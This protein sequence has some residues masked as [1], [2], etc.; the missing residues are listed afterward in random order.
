MPSD[1]TAILDPSVV[2][3]DR[4]SLALDELGLRIV[5]VDW[6]DSE[7]ELFLIRQAN[8]EIPA[9]HHPPNRTITIKLR[10]RDEK[11][12]TMA[13]AIRNLQAKV[14]RIQEESFGAI[15]R[16]PDSDSDFESPVFFILYGATLTG[17]GGWLMAHR[18][19]AN[20]ITL[21]LNAGP[22]CYGTEEQETG[23]VKGSEVRQLEWEINNILGTAPGL[24][25]MRIKNE[26]A[27]SWL[28]VIS[29]IESRDFES[30]A[31]AKMTM[32]AESLTPIGKAVITEKAGASGS[33]SEENVVTSGILTSAWAGI[34]YSKIAAT[35][36]HLSH[37]GA[38]RVIVRL[39]DPN[40]VAGSVRLK[41][42]WRVLGANKWIENEEEQTYL[43]GDFSFIDFGEVRPEVA[44]IGDRRWEFMVI[45]KSATGE[46]L[47]V[48][49]DQFH[50]FSTEQY[51]IVQ[52]ELEAFSGGQVMWQDGFEQAAGN[53]TG[54]TAPIGGEYE[55]FGTGT[56]LK[57]NP[58]ERLLESG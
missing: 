13:R 51:L 8:G 33:K 7:H 25:R 46:E 16:V 47:E 27:T 42:K 11:G 41:L 55:G 30:A 15:E 4:V 24:L 18:K 54:K 21:T 12:T 28:G 34:L 5:E 20:E 31:S 19:V 43:V 40:K 23:E 32:E 26:G 49:L 50:F 53:V 1:E 6:G 35:A 22:Y 45:A 58:T 44:T 14:G 3:P 17:I 57:V 10:A 9:D 29:A 36:E 37:I 52:E 2:L 48:E 39:W 56:D 38:R